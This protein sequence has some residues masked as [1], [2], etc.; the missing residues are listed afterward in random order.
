MKIKTFTNDVY[1]NVL[2]VFNV[3][4]SKPGALAFGWLLWW[5]VFEF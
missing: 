3:R 5:I 4:F 2:P 1:I